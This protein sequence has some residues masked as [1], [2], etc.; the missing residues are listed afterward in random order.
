MLTLVLQVFSFVLAVIAAFIPPLAMAPWGR[1]HFGW[2][3]LAF[4]V[5]SFLFGHSLAR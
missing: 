5:A 1:L 2:L 3:S 4:L